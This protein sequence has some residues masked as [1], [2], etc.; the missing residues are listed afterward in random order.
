MKKKSLSSIKIEIKLKIKAAAVV[1]C[2]FC[3]ILAVSSQDSQIESQMGL[4]GLAE[5][6]FR[7]GVQS[8]YRGAYN[9][10]IVIF[11]SALKYTPEDAKI[12]EWLGDAYYRAGIEGTALINWEYAA[13]MGYGGLLLQSKIDT[14]RTRRLEYP[15]FSPLTKLTRYTENGFFPGRTDTTLAF[16]QPVAL[17]PNSD[18]TF[19]ALAYSSNELVKIDAN[20]TLIDRNRGPLR[21]FDRPLDI[22]RL[23]DGS[24]LVSE[25]FGDRISRLS[26]TGAYIDSF[27]QKGRGEGAFIGPQYMALDEYENVYV[28][29]FGNARVCV[30]DRDGNALYS[31]GTVPDGDFP[32]FS[33]PT[34]IAIA[35]GIVFVADAVTGA[36]YKFDTSGN[37]SGLLVP[38]D[39]CVHPEALKVFG[40]YLLLADSNRVY[41]IDSASGILYEMANVGNLPSRLTYAIPDV[42]GNILASNFKSN[43][44]DVLTAMDEI[45]GG[46][47]VQIERVIADNFPQITLEISVENRNHS[48]V[49]GLTAEN[50][51]LT[52]EKRPVA[53]QTFGGAASYNDRCDITVLIDRSY[54]TGEYMDAVVSA[55]LEIAQAMN[56]QGTLRIVS[57]GFNPATEYAG[58]PAGVKNFSER[59]LKV[60]LTDNCRIDNAI[61]FAANDLINAEKKRAIIYLTSGAMTEDAFLRYGLT[62]LTAYLNNNH[63]SFYAVALEQGALPDEIIFVTRTT[64]GGIYYIYREAGIS[65]IVQDVLKEPNGSYRL[66]YTSSLPTDFGRNFLPVEIE[67]YLLN[68]SGRDETGYYKALE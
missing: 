65:S 12:L 18:A 22:A 52:E 32:G 48:A 46:F 36:I 63:I 3:S 62:N 9:E 68:R 55:V 66:T 58:N 57:A 6:D 50:F 15:E 26:E 17:L 43:E 60:P 10:A 45:V 27:G 53:N 59:S 23:K 47:F 20:G 41:T 33:A 37:Y 64:R 8:F 35:E 34:G 61:R 24:L 67:A 56:G 13:D 51:F 4:A 19:W 49:V 11:E 16:S 5:E 2:F 42:N 25:F 21:G 31:F 30:F 38:P 29:D 14:V 7:R 39:T 54:E 44:I 40:D 28:T 1:F